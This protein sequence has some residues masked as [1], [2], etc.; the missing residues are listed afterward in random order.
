MPMMA[1][2]FHVWFRDDGGDHAC[3]L[4]GCRGLHPN[5]FEGPLVVRSN[6]RLELEARSWGYS[7]AQKLAN[8]MQIT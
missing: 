7:Y 4:T 2:G 6:A 8:Q 1:L 3:D 5:C